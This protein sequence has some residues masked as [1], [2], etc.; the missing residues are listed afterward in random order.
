VDYAGVEIENIWDS[1]HHERRGRGSEEGN[2]SCS[3]NVREVQ[4]DR[5]S[6]TKGPHRKQ[7]FSR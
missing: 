6:K 5:S 3:R 4:A 7:A 1:V 2:G